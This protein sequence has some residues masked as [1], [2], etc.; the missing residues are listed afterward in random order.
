MVGSHESQAE[1][2]G[3]SGEETIGGVLMRKWQFMCQG[4]DFVCQRSFTQMRG[5]FRD[6][7][8]RVTVQRDPTSGMQTQEFPRAHRGQPQFIVLIFQFVL[9]ATRKLLRLAHAPNPDVRIEKK[10]QFLKA[11]IDSISITGETI[12]PTMSIVPDMEPIQL[13]SSASGDSGM[14]SA[15][16]LPR[17]VTRSGV[18]VLL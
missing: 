5:C 14:T 13:L 18:L 7:L 3:R 12:S 4:N 1:H 15:S 16:G 9:Y 6:P 11:S 2:P 10:F 17:R 8:A